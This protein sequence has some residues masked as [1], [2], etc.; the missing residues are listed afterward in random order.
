MAWRALTETDIK[1]RLSGPE[2]AAFRAVALATGQ[3]DP[4]AA[5]ITQVTDLVRGYIAAC[6][7]NR[8]GEEGTIP[9]KLIG[10]SVDMMVIEIQSR[11]AGKVIDPD[12]NRK[13]ANR[14]AMSILRDVAACRFGIEA[15]EDESEE[16]AA[17][18]TPTFFGREFAFQRTHQDGI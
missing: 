11:A 1:T 16:Q 3:T 18:N 17:N 14:T 10:P 2:L 7:S 8:L 15:P 9:T 4:V 12:G 6:P 13:E 5:V